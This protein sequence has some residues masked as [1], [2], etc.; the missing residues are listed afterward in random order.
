MFRQDKESATSLFIL[1]QVKKDL[2][3]VSA[4]DR[5]KSWFMVCA[6]GRPHNSYRSL[7]NYIYNVV[8]PSSNLVTLQP[9][10]SSIYLAYTQQVNM[11]VSDG[12]IRFPKIGVPPNHPFID[13]F[14]W[15][16]Q[17]IQLL[18]YPLDFGN[19]QF[20]RPTLTRAQALSSTL[21]PSCFRRM[22]SHCVA[23][24]HNVRRSFGGCSLQAIHW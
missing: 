13:G 17:T 8:S 12:F 6:N 18:G 2:I 23:W 14:S 24:Q 19:V 4:F 15:H 5:S 21:I 9:R 1:P 10:A 20:W 3:G 16:K 11:K 7:S 22:F